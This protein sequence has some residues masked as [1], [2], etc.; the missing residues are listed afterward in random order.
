VAVVCDVT[1]TELFI[2]EQN[3]NN[4]MPWTGGHYS[5]SFPLQRDEETGAWTIRDDED[6]LFGWVRTC[7]DEIVPTPAWQPPVHDAAHHRLLV[8]GVYEGETVLAWQKFVGVD[9]K[10]D[11]GDVDITQGRYPLMI[12]RMTDFALAAFLNVYHT[13]YP[14]VPMKSFMQHDPVPVTKK[15]QNFL[16]AHPEFSGIGSNGVEPLVESGE[17]DVATIKAAQNLLNKIDHY[18]DWENAL[19]YYRGAK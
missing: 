7:P 14:H 9:V 17:W 19:A 3:V 12:R 8:D 10:R 1:D 2:A 6:P 18:E 13:S 11:F 16:N 15:L 5:R 4:D